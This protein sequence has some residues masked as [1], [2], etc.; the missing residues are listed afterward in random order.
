MKDNKERQEETT[1]IIIFKLGEEE[2]GVNILQVREIEK[3]DQG[4]TRVPRAPHFVEGI[5]NLR[6]EIIPIVDLRARFGLTLPELGLNSRVIIVEV[7]EAQVGM[8]VDA[9][10]EVLRVPVS[11]IESAPTITKG[12]DSYFLAGVVNID[13]RLIVLL[14]LER[15]LSP[16]EE[17]ELSEVELGDEL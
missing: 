2:F 13:E 14:N 9:V 17:K 8:L 5:I 6:G 15:T 3:L 11:A 4:I 10:V 12:V 16:E 7:G 1:Q